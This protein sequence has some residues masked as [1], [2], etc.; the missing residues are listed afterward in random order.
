MGKYDEW[1]QVVDVM[2]QL[3]LYTSLTATTSNTLCL[4]RRTHY[5]V[6]QFKLEN[7]ANLLCLKRSELSAFIT[8]VLTNAPINIINPIR[9]A[10]RCVLGGSY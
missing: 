4:G 8:A 2:S 5:A 6:M 1:P 9:A 7:E 10:C 3:S